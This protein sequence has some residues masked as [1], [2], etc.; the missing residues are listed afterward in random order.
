MT[1]YS[2]IN[3]R[4]HVMIRRRL[5][6]IP[7]PPPGA[8]ATTL[9]FHRKIMEITFLLWNLKGKVNKCFYDID[10]ENILKNFLWKKKKRIN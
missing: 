10:L 8:H 3:R 5:I 4:L 7:R 6:P 1:K 2:V 9:V